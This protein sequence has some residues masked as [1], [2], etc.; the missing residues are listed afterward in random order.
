MGLWGR[1]SRAT[2]AFWRPQSPDAS[3]LNV[4]KAF[5]SHRTSLYIWRGEFQVWW[6]GGIIIYSNT[7]WWP[8]SDFDIWGNIGINW[9]YVSWSNCSPL[10]LREIF[11]LSLGT[12]VTEGRTHGT[13]WEN[14]FNTD[15]CVTFSSPPTTSYFV[16]DDGI[17]FAIYNCLKLGFQS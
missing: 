10:K 5:L 11:L 13:Y 15:K 17:N 2:G 8:F 7:D 1:L 9:K 3:Y 4:Y 6:A 14:F 16:Y 12:Y